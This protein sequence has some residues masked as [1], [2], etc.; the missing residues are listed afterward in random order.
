MGVHGE[1]LSNNRIKVI[2]DTINLKDLSG[3][4]GAL[5]TSMLLH[6]AA[7]ID[8]RSI[9]RQQ[10]EGE[11]EGG[12]DAEL[13]PVNYSVKTMKSLKASC[14][15]STFAVSPL[16][17]KERENAERQQKRAEAYEAA[18]AA[19]A[20]GDFKLATKMYFKACGTSPRMRQLLATACAENDIPY[21]KAPHEADAQMV[22]AVEDGLADFIISE[23]ADMLALGSTCTIFKINFKDFTGQ[24]VTQ[25]RLFND[26]MSGFVGFTPPM[27]VLQNILQ[28]N[29]YSVGVDGFGI[30]TALELVKDH[31]TLDTVLAAL[32]QKFEVEEGEQLL[33]PNGF[34]EEMLQQAYWTMRGYPVYKM[35]VMD[36]K[37]PISILFLLIS[38]IGSHSF[39]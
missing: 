29:D 7:M 27:L 30:K 16:P 15:I 8:P 25:Q 35:T 4:T 37:F 21:V 11:F 20:K 14:G 24:R 28:R 23:D 3:N 22:R 38:L 36:M 33:L 13:I 5:D 2:T 32:K 39:D 17:A 19:E 10:H 26:D 31:K 18:K 1:Y 12:R 6:R 34:S 9:A